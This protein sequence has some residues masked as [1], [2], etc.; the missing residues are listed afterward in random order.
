MMRRTLAA[1]LIVLAAAPLTA[2]SQDE[3]FGALL[4]LARVKRDAGDLA[5]ARQYF[6]AAHR[7]R[8]L[9]GS[10]LVEYFWVL[11]N[12]D[13]RAAIG[14][15]HDLLSAA[16]ARADVRDAV[17]GAAVSLG[18][19]ATVVALASEGRRLDPGT[20][21][22]PRRLG[23]SYL[24]TGRAAMAVA[25]Y[26]QAIEAADADPR[27]RVG[28]AIALE[29]AGDLRGAAGAWRHVPERVTRE[30]PAWVRSR[31]R[32]TAAAMP[33]RATARVSRPPDRSS[34]P[35]VAGPAPR[36]A[37]LLLSTAAVPLLDRRLL[38]A[39][40]VEALHRAAHAMIR[41]LE[42]AE[43]RTRATA[44]WAAGDHAAAIAAATEVT[45]LVPGDGEAW[46][47]RVAATASSRS[48]D[49]L[50]STI[51]TFV[52]ARVENV[53]LLIGLAEHLSG[54]VRAPDDPVIEASL[55]LLDRA[56][57]DQNAL[58]VALA[59][60]RLLAAADR[61]TDSL[62]QIEQ[63]ITLDAASAAA[64]RLR[65]DVLSWAGRH[66]EAILAYERYFAISDSDADARRQYARVL[67]WSGRHA[68]AIR[69]YATLVAARP[70]DG[71]LAAEAAAKRAFFQ[72]RWRAA[73]AAYRAWLVIEPRNAEAR[74]ELAESLRASGDPVSA[75]AGLLVLETDYGH[76]LAASAR[77]RAR[78]S[79]RPFIGFSGERRSANGYGG[80]RLLDLEMDGG[81]LGFS[82]GDGG[83][84]RLSL[85]GGRVRAD[86]GASVRTGS[87][88]SAGVAS[89]V[90]P[91]LNV[92]GDA[93]SWQIGTGEPV[94]EFRGGVEWQPGDRW[95][96]DV[97]LERSAF[98]E[99]VG[100]IDAGLAAMGLST[101]LRFRSP[102]SS[103]EMRASRDAISDG[104]DRIRITVSGNRA[105]GGRLARVRLLGWG[106]ALAF[107]D[108]RAAYFSPAR[109]VR[110]DAGL[111]YVSPLARPRFQGDRQGEFAVGYLVGTD[112]RGT[113]YQ[114]P[115]MRLA[116]EVRPG[117]AVEARGGW[118]HSSTYDERSLVLG[119]RLGGAAPR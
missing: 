8:P 43:A 5:A 24:R 56:G 77:A 94:V 119:L 76:R 60:A 52:D 100:T 66:D 10:E 55:S 35:T 11:V 12:V 73:V 79:R 22:W 46:F 3:R 104:N 40:R 110:L 111:E 71:A 90:R 54:L 116:V 78:L 107:G 23:E 98:H 86:G 70:G 9:G 83:G 74:F 69:A 72:G 51:Q 82:A 65:A 85:E 30:N 68:E 2:A 92:F 81:V 106:E 13:R 57:A 62:V 80:A 7:V 93:G 33:S 67:G 29:A 36:D 27:D 109:F 49:E 26:A 4:G 34:E 42:I 105:L 50:L 114:H 41:P 15:G 16:P 31:A 48:R 84:T 117:I 89:Q 97:A 118:I 45:S 75:D 99:N 17:I 37:D 39:P 108:A 18:D 47:I 102:S 96:V 101:R 28:L 14:L 61:W 38:D 21:R 87:R 20:A 32:A 63:A 53:G 91:G 58:G 64:W 6:D 88:F 59:R 113:L 95:A 103:V 115:M 1:C 112:D 25:A 19:E 44:R